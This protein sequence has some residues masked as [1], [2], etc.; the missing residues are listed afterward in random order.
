MV[1]PA[2]HPIDVE[3]RK[4]PFDKETAQAKPA[5]DT[6]IDLGKELEFFTTALMIQRG[7]F[8]RDPVIECTKML[9]TGVKIFAVN[10]DEPLFQGLGK[11]SLLGQPV[12][13]DHRLYAVSRQQW[14]PVRNF[15]AG[16]SWV[17]KSRGIYARVMFHELSIIDPTTFYR[18]G[19][20]LS[21]LPFFTI[22]VFSVATN[23]ELMHMAPAVNPPQTRSFPKA[24]PPRLEETLAAQRLLDAPLAPE[25]LS[26]HRKDA[27]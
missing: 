6:L 26:R 5:G 12:D 27:T 22:T 21:E 10:T 4:Q 8:D 24:N 19:G 14:E 2:K 9:N 13:W 7:G 20:I 15:I 11:G 23:K 3:E 17:D 1:D 25:T 18:H 16:L